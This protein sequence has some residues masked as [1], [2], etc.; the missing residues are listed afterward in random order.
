MIKEHL[1][2]QLEVDNQSKFKRRFNEPKLRGERQDVL[3]EIFELE[4][5]ITVLQEK[6][7]AAMQLKTQQETK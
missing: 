6:Q 4:K 7:L 5:E 2:A 3:N 1:F